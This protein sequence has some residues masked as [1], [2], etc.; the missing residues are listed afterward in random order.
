MISQKDAV[1]YNY[2]SCGMILQQ[3]NEV[4]DTPHNNTATAI[5]SKDACTA[6]SL[7]CGTCF[8]SG[9]GRAISACTKEERV[10][11]GTDDYCNLGKEHAHTNIHK[12]TPESETSQIPTISS[13]LPLQ[14]WRWCSFTIS[15]AP[16]WTP[17]APSTYPLRSHVHKEAK[18]SAKC[19]E[20]GYRD[21]FREKL[22]AIQFLCTRLR[23]LRRGKRDEC[24]TAENQDQHPTHQCP[25]CNCLPALPTSILSIAH[26]NSLFV[27]TFQTSRLS[28]LGEG[29]G[30]KM[31]VG[32]RVGQPQTFVTC[33]C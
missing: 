19:N 5:H 28:P 26:V 7:N 1:T 16:K 10:L 25:H 30:A 8:A 27:C 22:G 21:L 12:T 4:S 9:G 31:L 29:G 33:F 18:L 32:S 23:I 14:S 20:E 24:C 3:T 6:G 15:T 11:M 2:T 17:N 13:P